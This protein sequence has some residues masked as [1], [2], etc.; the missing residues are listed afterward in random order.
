MIDFNKIIDFFYPEANTLRDILLVHSKGVA[1]LAE[2]ILDRHPELQADREIVIAGAMIHDI[3]IRNCD[4]AGIECYGSEP[5]IC[6]GILGAD[7]IRKNQN[8]LC[9]TPEE[10][11]KLARICERHTGTGLTKKQIESQNLPLPHRD[12]TPETLEEQITCYSDTFFSTT[13]PEKKK[14][15]DKAVRSL[16]KFGEEG[17]IVFERWHKKFG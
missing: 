14:T 1:Q 16:Q 11:E 17:L 12:L 4:A 7:M 5:Y 10:S 15:Y 2:E 13:H 3:G 6:H 8:T 9:L